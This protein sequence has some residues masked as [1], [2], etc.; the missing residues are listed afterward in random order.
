MND[1]WTDVAL[2]TAEGARSELAAV[3]AGLAALP[4]HSPARAA[5]AARAADLRHCLAAARAVLDAYAVPAGAE[6]AAA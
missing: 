3:Q 2:A 1:R 5:L 4:V 6:E